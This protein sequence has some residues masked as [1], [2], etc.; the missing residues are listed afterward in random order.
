MS[1]NVFTIEKKEVELKSQK[2]NYCLITINKPPM[3]VLSSSVLADLNTTIDKLIDMKTRVAIFT[4]EGKA[5]IAGADISEMTNFSPK[6]AQEFSM[7]GQGVLSKLEG[8]PFMSIAAVNGF[9]F[10]GGLEFALACD[11]RIF[12]QKAL[13]GLPEVSLGL[14]PGFGGTQRLA[15]QIGEG[16]AKYYITTGSNI[17]A[18]KALELGLTQSIVPAEDLLSECEKVASKILSNG[19]TAVTM[20]KNLVF[21]SREVEIKKG[22]DKEA[23]SFGKLFSSDEAKEGTTAFLEKRP[24][25]F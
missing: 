5:F 15:R 6:E 18:T 24:A 16:N 17:D 8:A 14:I 22:L 21:S 12:S 10:G 1:Q 11:L 23:T 9:A 20:A 19:P 7:A 2:A 25:K 4:G 3:N 13:I